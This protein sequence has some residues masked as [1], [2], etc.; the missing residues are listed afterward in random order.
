MRRLLVVW[1]LVL[2]TLLLAPGVAL[3]APVT[4]ELVTVPPVPE[5]RFQLDDQ[6][7]I[8]DEQGVARVG[9]EASTAKRTLQ[10]INP[11]I[12]RPG[13]TVEFVRWWGGGL[14]DLSFTAMVPDLRVRRSVRIQVGFRIS[15]QIAFS[16]V[17][18]TRDP[19]DPERISVI[20]I[21]NDAGQT[22]SV[23]GGEPV[24]LTG[25]RPFLE[26]S[27]LIA[28]PA[29]Y[30]VQSIEID[31]SNAVIAGEQRFAPDQDQE[32]TLTVPLRSVKFR[33]YDLLFGSPSGRLV[34]LTYPD[35]RTATVPL[36]GNGEA[37]V[38]G[39]V[40]G[41]YTM[42]V[43]GEGYAPV[44]PIALSRSQTVRF[45]VLSYADVA[46]LVGSALLLL[47]G[48]LLARRH[49][50]RDMERGDLERGKDAG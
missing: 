28:K 18:Q 20:T 40:R 3:A 33:A 4:L 13:D 26:R 48:L 16:V 7:L 10:L 21:K 43:D 31:G 34:E 44:Q 45:P 35:G 12:E 9:L 41:S 39:L 14:R 29:T 37:S 15:Y 47:G 19:V 8:T 6:E 11:F 27:R 17:D 32:I 23:T 46:T 42:R 25:V 2:G 24:M 5:A 38:G 30:S 50:R 49:R 22:E 1:S 36:D